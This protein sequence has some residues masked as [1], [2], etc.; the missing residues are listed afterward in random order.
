M[1][2]SCSW[3]SAEAF[4]TVSILSRWR[5]AE[6]E[7]S[8]SYFIFYK[9]TPILLSESLI[10][11]ALYAVVW[12]FTVYI[13]LPQSNCIAQNSTSWIVVGKWEQL[14]LLTIAYKSITIRVSDNE[15]EGGVRRK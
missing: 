12:S 9:L 4:A 14:K 15:T 7:K 1:T 10:V 6:G 3:Y 13:I 2:Q 5:A 8:E 11:I